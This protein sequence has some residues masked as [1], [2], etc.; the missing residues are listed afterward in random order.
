MARK[1]VTVVEKVKIMTLWREKVSTRGI[2]DRTGVPL[3]TVERVIKQFRDAPEDE[4][5]LRKSGSGRPKKTPMGT[6][7]ALRRSVM[8][9]PCISAKD[10]KRQLPE[11]LGGVSIRTIQR[12]LKVDLQMPCR[13]AAQKPLINDKMRKKRLQFARKY[14]AWTKEQWGQVMFSDESTFRTLRVVSRTIRRPKGSYRYSSRYTVKT[15]KHPAGVMV[16][17]C[18]TGNVG[19]GSIYFLPPKVTMTGDR[20]LSMLKDKLPP[21]MGIHNASHFLQ[22]GAPCHKTKKVMDWFKDQNIEVMDWPGNSPDLNPI[23]NVWSYMKNKLKDK[24]ITS[25]PVLQQEILKLW[26]MEITQDYFKKLT[27]SMPERIK[28]VLEHRGE[29]TK[30]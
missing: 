5:P 9:N 19:R 8:V 6:S 23:E 27:D 2:V 13:K 17:A 22:D 14:K 10:L 3:R 16:W 29:M 30:Y 12:R 15:M 1:A 20:Y 4:L 25:V 26:T 21:F 28:L 24:A 7:K 18:F 11:Y